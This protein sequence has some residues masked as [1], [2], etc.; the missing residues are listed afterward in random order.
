MNQHREEGNEYEDDDEYDGDG[1]PAEVKGLPYAPDRGHVVIVN[2]DLGRR[3][4]IGQ[5]MRKPGR[6]CVVVQNN[7]IRRGRLVTVVPLSGKEPPVA[8]PYH[9]RM[10]HRSFVTMPDR[11]GGQ[12]KPRWAKCDYLT[13]VSLERCTSPYAKRPYGGR[14]YV[15]VRV[16]RADLDEIEK[17]I[18]WALGISLAPP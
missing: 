4:T 17:C 14:R 7:R 12:A 6:P 5:E 1:D 11:Y 8:Q 13:T 15:K 3:G 10:D 9:H 18:L 2:F 16:T